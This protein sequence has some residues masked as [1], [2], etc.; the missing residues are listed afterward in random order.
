MIG[1]KSSKME[2][3]DCTGFTMI[4]W[5]PSETCQII[6]NNIRM[7]YSAKPTALAFRLGGKPGA[8]LRPFSVHL[9][10]ECL[11]F[12]SHCELCQEFNLF[13]VSI[14]HRSLSADL[15]GI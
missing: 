5:N 2:T 4:T 6:V 10:H 9:R 7:G 1:G 11:F 14:G 3:Y 8:Q 12:W 15:V 13:S